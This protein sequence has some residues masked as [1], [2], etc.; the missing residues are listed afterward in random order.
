M[1]EN[2]PDGA[3][4]RVSVPLTRFHN[5][6]GEFLDLA[7]VQ[8]VTLTKHDRVVLTICEAGYFERLEAFAAA[9]SGPAIGRGCS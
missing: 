3:A 2:E 8:P 4:A 5:N 1:A 6:T 7:L 9:H